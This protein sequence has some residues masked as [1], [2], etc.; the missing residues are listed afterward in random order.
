MLGGH[1]SLD[2]PDPIPNSEVKRTCADDSVDY[3]CESRSPP[4]S[5]SDK[6]PQR[7]L[8]GGLFLLGK[9]RSRLRVDVSFIL[10][11]CY[12]GQI[13]YGLSAHFLF[14][15]EIWIYTVCWNPR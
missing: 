12:N 1:S 5:L 3:P 4:G 11:I 13:V 10:N 9:I 6:P 15:A 7:K 14:V 2:P 8:Q